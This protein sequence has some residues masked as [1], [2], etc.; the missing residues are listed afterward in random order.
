MAE[1]ASLKQGLGGAFNMLPQDQQEA[2]TEM[3]GGGIVAFADGGFNPPDPTRMYEEASRLSGELPSAVYA[4]PTQEQ[5][6][7]GIRGQR[8]L[9]RE[10]MGQDRL[11][12]FMEELAAQRKELQTGRDRDRGFA[13]LAAVAPMLE[14]RGLASIGRGVSKFGSELGRLEKENRD[15]DRLLL[16]SQTQLASA[17][18]AR[19]D[20]Q[21]DKANQLF[22]GAEDLKVKALD[23]KRDVL[24][25]QATLQATLGGQALSAQSQKYSTDTSAA[26][27]RYATDMSAKTQRDLANK[28]GETERI[29]D[30]IERIQTGKESF[31]GKTGEEGVKLYKQSLGEVGAAKYGITEPGGARPGTT[32]NAAAVETA[33]AAALRTDA[34]YQSLREA[35]GITRLSMENL[36][37]IPEDKRTAQQT[38]RLTALQETLRRQQAEADTIRAQVEAKLRA[39]PAA[40]AAAPAASAPLVRARPD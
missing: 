11:A 21:F 12:P 2:V 5:T 31:G 7:A 13:A 39:R 25:R 9:V 29:M 6:A 4:A 23:A 20:G 14:G 32:P 22:R 18:Q 24:G 16:A 36:A 15:A 17:Q 35:M 37:K 34:P 10:M 19:E 26:T 1:R 33:V 27:S 30:R 3:A 28:P 38:A 8:D 40:A